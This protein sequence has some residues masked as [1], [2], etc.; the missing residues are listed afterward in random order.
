M[1]ID[2]KLALAEATLGP[3]FAARLRAAY[4]GV[5]AQFPDWDG[6]TDQ[7]CADALRSLLMSVAQSQADQS[8]KQ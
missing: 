3:A 8:T 5:K 7:Q 6:T 2:E 4:E 1:T